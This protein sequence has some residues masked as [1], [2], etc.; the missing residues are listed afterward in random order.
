MHVSQ[1]NNIFI[2]VGLKSGPVHAYQ[3][4]EFKKI[5]ENVDQMCCSLTTDQLLFIGGMQKVYMLHSFS[6]EL[7]DSISTSEWVFSL[8]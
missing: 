7:I 2:L 3:D 4:F 1:V 8:C 5:L 6:L